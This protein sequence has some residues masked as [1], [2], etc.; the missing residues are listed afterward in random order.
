MGQ[1]KRQNP[2]RKRI[3]ERAKQVRPSV[4]VAPSW[5]PHLE[6]ERPEDRT[7]LS[8]QTTN[9]DPSDAQLL[10]KSL[11]TSGDSAAIS[12]DNTKCAFTVSGTGLAS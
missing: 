10:K 2:P 1:H 3:L 12:Y 9:G 4:H 7:L 8:V 6:I 11:T 5:M